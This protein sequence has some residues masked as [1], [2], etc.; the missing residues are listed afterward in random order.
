[1]GDSKVYHYK[2]KFKVLRGERGEIKE[3]TDSLIWEVELWA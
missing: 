2:K 1:V 3:N